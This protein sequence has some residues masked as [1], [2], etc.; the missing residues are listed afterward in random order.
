MDV[1]NA[2]TAAVASGIPGVQNFDQAM[3]M[4]NATVGVGDMKMS[5][6]ASAFSTG[7]VATVKGYGLSITDVS[8][9]L[10]VF[11]DNNIRGTNA[12]TNLRMAVQALGKPAA[13]GVSTLRSIGLQADS[14][15]KDMQKGGLKLALEDLV[16]HMNAAGVS[17]DK[18]GQII[19][20]AFG[21]KAGTGLN[22]LVGQ[23]DRL[24][25]KY[26]ALAAGA[27]GFQDAWKATTETAAF[28]AKA[29]Q[30]SFDAL[31]I[32]IGQKL[33]PPLQSLLGLLSAHKSI[34]MGAVAATLGLLGAVVL[35][36]AAM[37][38]AAAATALWSATTKGA[39]GVSSVFQTVA[40]K[41]M[42]MKDAFAAA[43]G[44][45][46]GLGA[47]IGTLSTGTKV[48]GV[49][50]IAAGL[51]LA[52]K[53]FS[54][55]A[56]QAKVS[57]DDMA[58]SLKGLAAGHS[59]SATIAQLS[60]DSGNL[61]QSFTQKLSS[62]D[63][64]WDI[65]TNS[66]AKTSSA[67][68]DFKNVGQA[69]ADMVKNGD[70]TTAAIAL[71]KLTDAGVKVPTKYLDAYT[72]ALAD[73]QYQS[74]LT[75]QSQG[76][77]G[78]EAQKVKADLDVQAAAADG[79]A[80]SLQA[81]DKINQDAYNGETK[82]E[83]T[84][85][86]ATAAIKTNGVTLDIHTDKGRANRDALSAL[87]SETDAYTTALVKQGGSW[88]S[89]NNAYQRGY[90]NLVKDAMAMGDSRRQA[91]ALASSLL[92]VPKEVK[93]GANI[94]DLE[95]QLKKAKSELNS[96]P[97]SK[98]AAIQAS[99]TD[100]EQ[101]VADAKWQLAQLGDK[102]ITITT[103]LNSVYSGPQL[104]GAPH[105][106]RGGHISGPGTGTSDDVPIMASNGEFMVNAAQ[107]QKHRALLEAINDGVD[108]YAD[109]GLIGYARGGHVT[110]HR[111]RKSTA[112]PKPTASQ[113]AAQAEQQARDAAS[114][115]FGI[116]YY[117]QMA[118]YQATPFEAQ[119]SGAGSIDAL[120]TTLNDWR[121][122][123]AAATHG[124]TESK[125]LQALSNFGAG[126]MNSARMLASVN[127]QLDG[128][129]NKL[130]TLQGS[131]VQLRDSIASSI[132]AYGSIVPKNGAGATGGPFGQISI[133]EQMR[134]SVTQAHSF[135]MALREL[136]KKGLNAQSISEIAAAGI[137]GGGLD[138]AKRL[139][140][141]SAGGI[142]E[143]NALEKQL[144]GAAIDAGN[145]TG[146]AM[147]GGGIRAAE[148]LVK[149]LEKSQHRIEA[150][151]EAAADAMAA[152]IKQDFGIGRKASGGIVGAAASGGNRWGRTLVGEYAPEIVD[153]P[154]GS[155]VHS[156]P[157]TA[158]MLGGGVSAAPMHV[159]I[160]I[161]DREIGSIV[162]DP[163]RRE[164]RNQGGN[165]QA[166]LGVRGKG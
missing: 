127:G 47:A 7:M 140:G 55:Q 68:K 165:V 147:Y 93:V 42:Y 27:M 152:R 103:F 144:Q 60:K 136:K 61:R 35:V 58:T 139:L 85:S 48:A 142:K 111:K 99:I 89:V 86:K 162:I 104:G 50:A 53:Y 5:D 107:A 79:L 13:G 34:T 56:K 134:Q 125:L 72:H 164:I 155:R 36:S 73:T 90:N 83:D 133:Q 2:L 16:A 82:F 119:T 122:K 49:V 156:G 132:T 78:A 159:T 14:L 20:N 108:G 121:G 39:A 101:K 77:F 29:L 138:T 91:E 28:Q 37:K 1:T 145:T 118:G 135:A 74:E 163:L 76:K 71:K 126:M 100:L 141:T 31:M 120:V 70:T 123:I 149:G 10:A 117:G 59:A 62:N 95:A 67:Q 30:S 146:D 105:K 129:R 52:F 102:N 94:S 114:P 44:G 41:S 158:R 40:L 32:G 166:V 51:A 97:K 112:K 153:L 33:M 63:S 12:A 57:A 124:A 113:A 19:T 88:D 128:A 3:G 115:D 96:V 80:Q 38:T 157:D 8:A 160:V 150:V 98:K 69:L 45:A 75:A 15:A 87:A 23:I 161:G 84:I 25:S 17:S 9:A 4:L 109:G 92:H 24:E 151:M 130:S 154:I 143:I 148:A 54:D 11:G 18:Q 65:I 21:K 116:S 26:P 137:D 43:G 66:G 22:I 131:F 6:L 81:L 106:A 64:I 110:R 46:R